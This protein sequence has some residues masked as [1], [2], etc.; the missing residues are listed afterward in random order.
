MKQKDKLVSL[1]YVGAGRGGGGNEET[2]VSTPLGV[3]KT[4]AELS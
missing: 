3:L 1:E 4:V 2:A